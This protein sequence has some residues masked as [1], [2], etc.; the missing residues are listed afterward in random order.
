MHARI[1][2]QLSRNDE[3]RLELLPV[4]SSGLR[5]KINVPVIR[6]RFIDDVFLEELGMVN[7]TL[8]R[9][10]G[11]YLKSRRQ[12]CDRLKHRYRCTQTTTHNPDFHRR[13]HSTWVCCAWIWH[14]TF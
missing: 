9:K 10:S 3:L 12:K 13:L 6:L 1:F 8:I 2:W 11:S 5:K 7:Q 14:F 4:Y